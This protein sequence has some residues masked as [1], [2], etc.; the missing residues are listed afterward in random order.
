M[1]TAKQYK[2]WCENHKVSAFPPSYN[3]VAGFIAQKVEELKGS[4]KSVANMVSALR[5]FCSGAGIPWITEADNFQLKRIRRQLV[6]EDMEEKRQME[7]FVLAMIKELLETGILDIDNSELDLLIAL[8]M[9]LAHNGLLR[10]AELLCGLQAE[11]IEF[12]ERDHSVTIHLPPTKTHRVGAGVKVRVT[13]YK[14]I[15]AYKLMRRWFD[16]FSLKD[17]PKLYVFPRW[18][19]AT[20]QKPAHFDFRQSASKRWFGRVVRKMATALGRAATRY[21]GHSFRAGGATDLF[22]MGVPYP[23]IKLYGR[24][25]S[26]A[27]LVYYRSNIE[28]ARTV[29]KAF[30]KGRYKQRREYDGVGVLS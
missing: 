19:R 28:V 11:D 18:E 30:G 7:P 20:K 6:L 22:I 13:D 2:T 23:K 15:S 12:D 27:A 25:K 9:L 16:M 21:S 26:D 29:A 5:V 14:G 3:S 17:H 4:T 1:R 24:W 8:M 10:G